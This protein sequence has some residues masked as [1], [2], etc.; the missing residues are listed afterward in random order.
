[1]QTLTNQHRNK[2]I[3]KIYADFEA[4]ILEAFGT[5]LTELKSILD[6]P[7]NHKHGCYSLET[8]LA[9]AFNEGGAPQ[10]RWRMNSIILN[11]EYIFLSRE[12]GRNATFDEWATS[13]ESLKIGLGR[14]DMDPSCLDGVTIATPTG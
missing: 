4:N 13:V 11:L 12:L 3:E 6:R 9:E 10:L 8:E 2:F 5:N 7:N 14:Q 1:M